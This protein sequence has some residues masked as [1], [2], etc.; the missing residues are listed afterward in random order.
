LRSLRNFLT[1]HNHCN[2]REYACNLVKAK[3]ETL[4]KKIAYDLIEHR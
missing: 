1:S 2:N 4:N 3:H